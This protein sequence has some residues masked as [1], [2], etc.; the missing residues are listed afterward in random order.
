MSENSVGAKRY[1]HISGKAVYEYAKKER[2][3]GLICIF[4]RRSE[5]VAAA[6]C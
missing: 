5:I 4:R 6:L 3:R 1:L 2:P